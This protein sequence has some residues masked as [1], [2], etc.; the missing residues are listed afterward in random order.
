MAGN[1]FGKTFTVTTFGE[2]RGEKTGVIID[3]CPANF[4]LRIDDIQAQLAR[5][6]PGQSIQTSQRNEMDQIHINSG[7]FEGK[8]TGMPIMA[9]VGNTDV[10]EKDYKHI[11]NHFRPSH[12][13]YAYEMKYGHRDYR[14]GSRASARET[15][16]RVIGGAIAQQI[17]QEKGL[18]FGAYVSQVGALAV[19]RPWEELAKSRDQVDAHPIRCPD[20]ECA[21]KMQALILA[22]VLLDHILRSRSY[23]RKGL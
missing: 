22:L 12:V 11:L 17:L 15:V 8:T 20:P 23:S 13:D 10:R 16:G 18:T 5:R 4:P 3:G 2:S 1:S 7:I 6:R 9:Y 21:T 19:Q 14:R